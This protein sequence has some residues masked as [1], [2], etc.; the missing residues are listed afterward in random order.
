M[1]VVRS[2][3]GGQNQNVAIGKRSHIVKIIMLLKMAKYTKIRK[4]YAWV[5][6]IVTLSFILFMIWSIIWQ[7]NFMTLLVKIFG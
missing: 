3:Q 4:F 1:F 6:F 5:G 2:P 7:D